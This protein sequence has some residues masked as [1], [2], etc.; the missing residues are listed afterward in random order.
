MT[1]ELCGGDL[2]TPDFHDLLEPIDDEDVVILVDNDL[3][4]GLDP[5]KSS[6]SVSGTGNVR[7][8]YPSTNVSLV[9]ENK[10]QRAV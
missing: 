6:L 8:S 2:E 3:V 5:S 1:L 4:S 10:S 7:G 9:L